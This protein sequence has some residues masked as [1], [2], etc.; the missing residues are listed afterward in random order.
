[1][2]KKE[3]RLGVKL[4]LKGD[5]CIG[6]KCAM[7]RRAYAPG[8][9]GAKKRRRGRSSSEYGELMREK[10]KMRFL[11][12]LDDRAVKRYVASA[13]R[14]GGVFGVNLIRLIERRLDVAVRRL[15]FAPSMP[16]ARQAVTHRRI[17]VNGRVVSS[18]SYGLKRGDVISFPRRAGSAE[19]GMEERAGIPVSPWFSLGDDGRS[20][21]LIADP[22]ADAGVG[23]FDAVKIK[24]FYSR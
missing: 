15:G 3:R 6:A 20:A 23:I 19:A 7:V 18:P 1:M 24:E 4:F 12:G 17:A 2:E 8:I 21:T 10:Q 11:Y 13:S 16:S 14:A 9:H 22:E 5:R